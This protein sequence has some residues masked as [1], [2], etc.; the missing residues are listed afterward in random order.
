M[1]IAQIL[2]PPDDKWLEQYQRHFLGETTLVKFQFRADN[3]HR[4]AGVVNTFAEQIL[5]ETPALALQHVAQRLERTV[6]GTCHGATMSTVVIQGIDR[7]LQ[8][9]FLVPDDDLR[10][11]ERQKVLQPVV[12]VDDTSVEIVQVGSGKTATLKRNQGAQIRRNYRQH[13][14]HHPLGPTLGLEKSLVNLDSLGQFLPNL[15][16]PRLGHSEL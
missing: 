15:L 13:R 5:T 4:A 14:Q 11:L 12:T 2:E 16:T 7:F 9:P 1:H 10:G 8:H 3:D 6:A